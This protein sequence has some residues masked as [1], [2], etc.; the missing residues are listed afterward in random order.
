MQCWEP[1]I[2]IFY[3]YTSLYEIANKYYIVYCVKL[4]YNVMISYLTIILCFKF[5]S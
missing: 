5:T 1:W 4:I 2:S 3:M